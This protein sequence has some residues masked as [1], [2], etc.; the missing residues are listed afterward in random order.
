V[1]GSK[2]TNVIM[3]YRPSLGVKHHTA[4]CSRRINMTGT[5]FSTVFLEAREIACGTVYF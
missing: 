2:A 3:A 5:P 1:R 4:S